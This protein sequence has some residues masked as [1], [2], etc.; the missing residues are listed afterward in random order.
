MT[1]SETMESTKVPPPKPQS[2]L[3]T[4]LLPSLPEGILAKEGPTKM[5]TE[6]GRDE[7][8]NTSSEEKQ[9]FATGDPRTV[10][11]GRRSTLDDARMLGWVGLGVPRPRGR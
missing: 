7:G 9:R 8:H 2:S 4:P 5:P 3:W 11:R 6:G 1:D 10:G